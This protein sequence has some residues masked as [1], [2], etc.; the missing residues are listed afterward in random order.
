ML[1]NLKLF[2]CRCGP[3]S[4]LLFSQAGSWKLS[5]WNRRATQISSFY[6]FN[7]QTIKNMSNYT[8]QEFFHAEI[9]RDNNKQTRGFLLT[10]YKFLLPQSLLSSLETFCPPP[11]IKKLNCVLSMLHPPLSKCLN[12]HMNCQVCFNEYMQFN[13]KGKYFQKT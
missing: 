7:K 2:T 12:L 11:L 5:G 4:G 6:L 3:R 13:M 8:Y 1:H 9:D 10:I